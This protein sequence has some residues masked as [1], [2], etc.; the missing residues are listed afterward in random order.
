MINLDPDAVRTYL[1][2]LFLQVLFATGSSVIGAL[3]IEHGRSVFA[4]LLA[5]AFLNSGVSLLLWEGND[6]G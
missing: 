5:A 4:V 1:P 6:N 2:P 3:A